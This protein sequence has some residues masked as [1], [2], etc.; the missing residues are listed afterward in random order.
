[1]WLKTFLRY[2]FHSFGFIVNA[3]YQFYF[4]IWE[5]LIIKI[6]SLKKTNIAQ[7]L[8]GVFQQFNMHFEAL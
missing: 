3:Y 8:Q 4:G 1:M 7:Q 2:V 6:S 5:F